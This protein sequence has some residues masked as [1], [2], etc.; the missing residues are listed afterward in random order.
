[1]KLRN[2]KTGEI[3]GGETQI[4]SPI[5]IRNDACVT[6]EYDSISELKENWEDYEPAEP[7][8]KDEKIRKAVRAW[9]DL[10]DSGVIR[11]YIGEDYV[12]LYKDD[13]DGYSSSVGIDLSPDVF[14]ELI[15]AHYY[16]IAELCGEEEE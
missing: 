9:A 5:L 16:T 6:H 15:D 3:V 14:R 8:I 2:K 10:Y 4:L 12:S 13:V 11:V 1:M 7:L